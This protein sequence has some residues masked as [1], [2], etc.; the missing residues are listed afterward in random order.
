MS[1]YLKYRPQKFAHVV[2]QD[3]IRVTLQN[4][5]KKDQVNHAYLFCG[6]R[7]TGKTSSARLIAK[8]I[9]CPNLDMKNIEPCDECDICSAI[10]D[11]KL[12]DIIEI[13]AASNRGIDEIR[14]LKE[15]IKFAPTQAKN[16]VYIID[17]VH[18]LT[19]EA[20]NA[21]LKT[22]EEPPENVFFILATTEVHKIPDTIISR[23]QR[24][25]F[26]RMTEKTI[27]A[28]LAFIA[29]TEG[30]DV[31][32]GIFEMIAAQVNGGL[33]DAIGLL[34]QLNIDGKITLD[35]ARNLIGSTGKDIISSFYDFLVKKQEAKALAV[36]NSVYSSGHDIGQFKK[37]FSIYLRSQLHISIDKND[38]DQQANV[39]KLI[40]TWQSVTDNFS[41][42]IIPQLSVE[43]FIVKV[44]L[45]GYQQKQV[46]DNVKNVQQEKKEKIEPPQQFDVPVAKK[47]VPKKVLSEI[48]V[49][50]PSDKEMNIEMHANDVPVEEKSSD[51]IESTTTNNS[52][53]TA[54]DWIKVI[55]AIN[56]ATLKRAVQQSVLRKKEDG[57][58]EIVFNSDFYFRTVNTAENIALVEEVLTNELNR[59]IALHP[60]V[61]DIKITPANIDPV[62]PKVFEDK[63]IVVEAMDMF[64]G[65]FID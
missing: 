38:K 42:S 33:R 21:L 49:E 65:E 1:L 45:G 29:Q 22:L 60:I 17:E 37:D 39:I 4:A 5:I 20:F 47:K 27:E 34:E 14:E 56:K 23:C 6:P 59:N 11:A 64:D 54:S 10:N 24:F 36:V 13:D 31:E 51:D 7:G 28:R 25:D 40:E 57:I 35:N 3:H 62:P 43:V 52:D 32:N 44:C 58:Y 9:N 15:T 48:P 26:R 8:A 63:D 16:K 2:G 41:T 18:M 61:D 55:T 46:T 30:I 19:T 12:I 50:A 53:I